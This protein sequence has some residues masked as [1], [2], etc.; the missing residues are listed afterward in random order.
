MPAAEIQTKRLRLRQ[1]TTEDTHRIAELGGDWDVA[2]MTSRMPYPYTLDA[3]AQW[4]EGLNDG[5]RVFGIEHEGELIG[6]TGYHRDAKANSAEI[7]YWIG[8]P[9]W[10]RGFATEAASAVIDHVFRSNSAAT[11]TCGHFDDNPASARVIE[12]LGFEKTGTRLWWCEARKLDHLAVRY[13]LT[14]PAG[15]WQKLARLRP[16]S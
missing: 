11:I 16:A 9:Y 3:A 15:F 12:K 5:E 4:I 14:K 2:S 10:G 1:L 8:K 13:E 6:V 7:G